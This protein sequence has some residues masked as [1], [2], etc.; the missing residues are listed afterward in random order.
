[1]N[2]EDK[3]L[4]NKQDIE[5][6]A[7]ASVIRTMNR[8]L[9]DEDDE[10]L[11]EENINDQLTNP[12][13][14][15]DMSLYD[16]QDTVDIG[17]EAKRETYYSSQGNFAEDTP[18]KIDE[19][20]PQFEESPT[21]IGS[22]ARFPCFHS[23]AQISLDKNK[24]NS[25][26]RFY[27]PN[28]IASNQNLKVNDDQGSNYAIRDFNENSNFEFNKEIKKNARKSLQGILDAA[29]LKKSSKEEWNLEADPR[30]LFASQAKIRKPSAENSPGLNKMARNSISNLTDKILYSVQQSQSS[31]NLDSEQ[32]VYRTLVP[33][34]D[35]DQ[36]EHSTKQ[37]FENKINGA[38]KKHTQFRPIN[39]DDP[40]GSERVEAS[41]NNAQDSNSHKSL[42][43]E[44]SAFD[45]EEMNQ[46]GMYP[47]GL[48][49][50]NKTNQ[51]NNGYLNSDRIIFSPKKNNSKF[52][53]ANIVST[54]A[55]DTGKNFDKVEKEELRI[56][57]EQ[58]EKEAAKHVRR[59]SSLVADIRNMTDGSP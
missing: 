36:S 25:Q 13:F 58:L 49:G 5:V 16:E 46:P 2:L 4:D 30:D 8:V 59:I 9:Y 22:K 31:L 41:E 33:S 40:I 50:F 1:M 42:D 55:L 10:E 12:G 38:I 48:E 53:N 37:L 11:F 35:K 57:N 23:E 29:M 27:K 45:D 52:Y 54:K 32:N 44:H 34:Y 26:V 39:N 51:D 28:Q 7:S 19:C 3:K 20:E 43:I 14:H 15:A 6:I 24:E 21:K 56:E 17:N 47:K 18:E